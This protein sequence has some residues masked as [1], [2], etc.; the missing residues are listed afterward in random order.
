MREIDAATVEDGFC[1][2][3]GFDLQVTKGYCGFTT[4]SPKYPFDAKVYEQMSG[5]EERKKREV[6][7]EIKEE[8]IRRHTQEIIIL[9]EKGEEIEDDDDDFIKGV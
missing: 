3:T 9:I 7:K 6:G 5:R 1:S 2:K 8:R 4:W